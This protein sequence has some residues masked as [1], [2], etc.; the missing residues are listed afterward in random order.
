MRSVVR[1]RAGVGAQEL[2][3]GAELLFADDVGVERMSSS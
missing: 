1:Q 2:L 3:E